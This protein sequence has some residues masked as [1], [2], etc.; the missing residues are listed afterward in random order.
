M[1]DFRPA[2]LNP[3]RPRGTFPP[4]EPSARAKNLSSRLIRA[5]RPLS[6]GWDWRWDFMAS[7]F[8]AEPG[9]VPC[10]Y[11]PRWRCGLDG[12]VS[13]PRPYR[14]QPT[15]ACARDSEKLMLV[16]YIFRLHTLGRKVVF[17]SDRINIDDFVLRSFDIISDKTHAARPTLRGLGVLRCWDS[18]HALTAG[19]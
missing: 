10:G 7:L 14:V 6:I 4:F 18:N 5:A 2:L 15:G 8:P 3:L 16:S 1:P 12:M 17:F 13:A 19:Q 11:I 9:V